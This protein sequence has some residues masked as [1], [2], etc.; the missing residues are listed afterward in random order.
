M[1]DKIYQQDDK[2][3]YNSFSTYFVVHSKHFLEFESMEKQCDDIENKILE[4]QNKLNH[5]RKRIERLKNNS[6]N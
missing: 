5:K 6:D 4:L 1:L 2:N 3:L